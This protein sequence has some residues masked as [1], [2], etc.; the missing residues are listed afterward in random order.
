MPLQFTHVCD[1]LESL[2]QNQQ[3][4]PGQAQKPAAKLIGD[5]FETHRETILLPSSSSSSSPSSSSSSSPS[6][7]GGDSTDLEALLSTLLPEKRTDRMYMLREKRLELRIARALCLGK[8]RKENLAAWRRP[9]A[10]MDLADCVERTL[11]EAVRLSFFFFSLFLLF[12]LLFL[13][14]HACLYVSCWVGRTRKRGRRA[15]M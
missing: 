10:G 12:L 2:E 5:W 11:R 14:D 8:S 9:G 4:R 6:Y 3:P 15:V 13:L 1:L 7:K